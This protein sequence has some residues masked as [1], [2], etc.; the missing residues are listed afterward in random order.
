M[1]TA[2]LLIALL[3]LFSATK[4]SVFAQS[5]QSNA[6]NEDTHLIG[7]L[8]ADGANSLIEVYAV[9]D[10]HGGT[11]ASFFLKKH[12]MARLGEVF[13]ESR[14]VEV[15]LTQTLLVLDEEYA[16]AHPT[17]S[18]RQGACALVLAKTN[19]EIVSANLGDS[20]AILIP[21]DA[22][23]TWK[24][25]NRMLNAANA[26]ENL[27]L[28][29]E[30]AAGMY[31]SE[32]RVEPIS[33]AAGKGVYLRNLKYGGLQP[34]RSIG[35]RYFRPVTTAIAE[36]TK[37]SIPPQGARIVLATDG[38]WD[39]LS[40]ADVATLATSVKTVREAGDSLMKTSFAE[41]AAKGRL[42]IDALERMRKQA[43]SRRFI[44]D[45]TILVF[46]AMKTNRHDEF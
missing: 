2:T 24:P 4:E 43:Q 28:H 8:R 11:T 39:E 27:R 29:K 25:L 17:E 3:T 34:T 12:F 20:Y 1:Y 23:H 5:R 33:E 37:M 40:A 7:R 14:S 19:D 46:D 42:S 32:F 35:D 9:F 45:T 31:P 44:D 13:E 21:L 18:L 22:P 36:I 38:L 10:G 15:A 6:V 30:I 26:D 41:A 16:K